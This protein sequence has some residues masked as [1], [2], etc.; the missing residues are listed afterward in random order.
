M[1]GRLELHYS[2]DLH[3]LTTRFL[4]D[5]PSL[6]SEMESVL[7]LVNDYQREQLLREQWL[8]NKNGDMAGMYP[9]MTFSRFQQRCYE[10]L[11]ISRR[12]L[13]F[14]E[15]CLLL[16]QI[17]LE[18]KQRLHYFLFPNG[19]FPED[20][21]R[22]IVRFFDT[23][24]LQE[25]E[26]ALLLGK[27][28]RLVLSTSDKL[29]A[30]LDLLF[31]VYVAF[32]DRNFMD[33]AALLQYIMNFS[34]AE[35]FKIYYPQLTSI[36]FEDIT[37]YKKL[38]IRFFEWLKEKGFSVYL[39]YPYGRNAEI[40]G[41]KINF[42]GKLK[43][44]VNH[45][46][47]YPE[48]QK[49]AGSLFQIRTGKITLHE[50]ISISSSVN[51]VKEV[52]EAAA[53]LK[54]LVL[55]RQLN[56][57]HIAVSSPQLDVYMPVLETVL[58]RHHIPFQI[59][60]RKKL[61]QAL[62]VKTLEVLVRALRDGYPLQAILQVV[63]SPFFRYHCK[64]TGRNVFNQ[65]SGM[66]VKS[67]RENILNFLEK[68]KNLEFRALPDE[69][70]KE[71][72]GNFA[73]L[74]EI[75][76]EFFRDVHFFQK[77]RT[78][79]ALYK[80]FLEL[81]IKNNI[82]QN[83][84]SAAEGK[85]L[86]WAEENLAAMSRL[87][88]ILYYWKENIRQC[89][90]TYEFSVQ[91]FYEVFTFLTNSAS[92]TVHQS[93]KTGIKLVPLDT[94]T[95]Y[96]LDA[97]IILGVED[98]VF[99]GR[100]DY[101]FT[102]PANLPLSLQP[103][104]VED[105]LQYE[106]EKFLQLLY[107]PAQFI[108]FSYAHFHQD[109]PL[110]PSVFIRELY[111]I[112]E[113]QL[114]TNESF[115]LYSPTDIIGEY[116][117]NKKGNKLNW[118]YIPESWQRYLSADSIQHYNFKVDVIS[119]R[120]NHPDLTVWEGVIP[121]D[122]P[123][124]SWLDMRFQK[125]RF[126]PTQ[127][128]LYAHCPQIFFFQRILGIEPVEERE[129]Y[130]SPMEKGLLV[131]SV[132]YRFFHDYEAAERN[133]QRL[134][135]VAEKEL[136]KM[137]LSEGLIWQLEK[138]FYLGN[139]SQ[140]GLFRA[141][142]NYEQEISTAFATIPRHFELSFGNS[143][144]IQ[145]EVDSFSSEAP[146][147]YHIQKEEFYFRGKID[148]VELSPDEALLIVDYKTGMLPTIREIWEGQRLQLPIYLAAVYRLLS[149]KYRHLAMG[150]GAFYGLRNEKDIEK[151]VIF[152]D[153][154]RTLGSARLSGSSRLP[155]EKFT[156]DEHPVTLE[157][158]VERSFRFAVGYIRAIRKGQFPHTQETERCRRWD[159]TLCEYLPLCRV[160]WNKLHHI[161]NDN[162]PQPLSSQSH[163]YDDIF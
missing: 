49:T 22:E 56:C 38:H 47:I 156:E 121:A 110:L 91:D 111:R 73:L 25:A 87:M 70:E 23:I 150:G 18:N 63:Q 34:P 106:R 160:N 74:E 88:E 31:S 98:G 101:S 119:K 108:R 104:M 90:S 130:L 129:E 158:L 141:F 112:S 131:H 30:D 105:Q 147:I 44:I 62:P 124:I 102:H 29:H 58:T 17:I 163:K 75:F 35:F 5:H 71:N 94:L 61:V 66:R 103:F 96:R 37:D 36:V 57:S 117:G 33:E 41:R 8:L 80:K 155:N 6:L 4:L 51:R 122:S 32:L 39:L 134:L 83:I 19:N 64:L 14:L 144:V 138:E 72:D 125:T 161:N 69:D 42:F 113:K 135:K 142:W 48:S 40:F 86:L 68:Q 123:V 9:F 107:H 99:P 116:A 53:L 149:Q 139:D 1:S 152:W 118:D 146:F 162:Y 145:N 120:E 143:P 16:K 52:E 3:Q 13:S 84:L 65:L 127:L 46:Q 148:R 133:P 114:E 26:D 27:K 76:R 93:F 43:N 59:E 54:R 100:S 67:G 78:A 95:S 136:R 89:G 159:G 126:S 15:K 79:E 45:M 92:Y 10:Q 128:E 24:R 85:N 137:P 81:L 151:R 28:Q 97:I 60:N 82:S 7:F 11:N 20:S 153:G 140:Q 12:I 109:Q 154:N 157:E 55:D 77:P 115:Q 50:R 132:L 21:V 2:S